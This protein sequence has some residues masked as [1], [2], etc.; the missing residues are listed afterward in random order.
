MVINDKHAKFML[1][2]VINS[3]SVSGFPGRGPEPVK[4][5]NFILM[6]EKAMHS[7]DPVLRSE[8]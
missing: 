5:K 2:L 8:L 3:I 4:I 7:K 6:H 1:H